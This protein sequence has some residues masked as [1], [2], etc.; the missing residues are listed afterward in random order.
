VKNGNGWRNWVIALLT[1]LLL[2]FGGGVL[3]EIKAKAD[4]EAVGIQYQGILREIQAVNARLDR[5]NA[6]LDR[7]QP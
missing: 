3:P 4:K 6:R 2:A 1:G 5:V 7:I